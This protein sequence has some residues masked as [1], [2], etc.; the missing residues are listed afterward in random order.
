MSVLNLSFSKPLF[1]AS[2]LF[3]LLK[4]LLIMVLQLIVFFS[5]KL[6]GLNPRSDLNLI[7]F[8][9]DNLDSL[10]L[11]LKYLHEHT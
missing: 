3:F 5:I 11:G 10:L 7:V 6:I 1:C 8:G 9:S 2:A 4:M